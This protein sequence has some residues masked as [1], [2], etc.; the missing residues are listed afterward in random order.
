MKSLTVLGFDFGLKYI[1]V[2]VG[3]S[4]TGTANP[5]LTVAA[6]HGKPRWDKIS[7]VIK[8]WRP[9]ALIVGMPLASDGSEQKITTAARHFAE[10][11]KQR[12]ALPVHLIDERYTTREAKS[13]LFA[14]GGFRALE[15]SRID[16]W[17][18]K[19]ITENGLNQMLKTSETAFP[20]QGKHFLSTKHLSL[21][22]IDRLIQAANE[23]VGPEGELLYPHQPLLPQKTLA[24]LFFENS[25]RTRSSFELAAQRLGMKVINFDVATSSVKKGESFFD[26]LDFLQTM[27]VDVFVIR[28]TDSGLPLEAAK[29]LANRASVINAGD[30]INEHPSQAMLDLFTIQYF[31]HQLE[32]LKIAIVGDIKHSRV[33]HS[34]VYALSTAGVRDIRL[35]GPSALVDFADSLPGL[36]LHTDLAQGLAGVD[37]VMMLRIQ[38]ER[39]QQAALPD[40]KVYHQYYGLTPDMLSHAKPNAIVMHP[41]PMNREVEISSEV[42][43]GPQSVILQQARFGVA[44]RMAIIQDLL[45]NSD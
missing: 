10:Q 7:E 19:I 23:W 2:A 16:G 6:D 18:A 43:D 8:Y 17:S 44:M 33:A 38:Q 36:S 40:L 35:V 39:M 22:D 26:T 42:A 1:G 45:K 3:Q 24:N 20:P 13:D 32:N 28:H 4:V 41:G 27:G 31:K 34:N 29:H 30:G 25:T 21:N 14:I 37:V 9:D 15:K 11:L 12:Y 5:L